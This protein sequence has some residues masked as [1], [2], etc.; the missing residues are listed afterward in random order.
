MNLSALIRVNWWFIGTP[1][2]MCVLKCLS[3]T[4]IYVNEVWIIVAWIFSKIMFWLH[5][6]YLIGIIESSL[7]AVLNLFGK[8]IFWYIKCNKCIKRLLVFVDLLKLASRLAYRHSLVVILSDESI[9]IPNDYKYSIFYLRKQV[10]FKVFF[11]K[12]IF[13]NSIGL[14]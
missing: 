4:P 1:C 2:I 9:I 8:S 12:N 7:P 6:F 11:L 10:P 5:T 14:L 13:W 3:H